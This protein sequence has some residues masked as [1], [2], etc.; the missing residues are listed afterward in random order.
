MRVEHWV[1][2]ERQGQVAAANMLGAHMPFRDAPFF[3]SAHYDTTIRY[4]GHAEAWDETVIDGDIAARD[5]SISYRRG[6]RTLAVA[7]IGRDIEN[8][9]AGQ[10]LVGVG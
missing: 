1:L 4:V 3:W 2:A 7:T 5:A 9:E 6:G 8:L 10:R